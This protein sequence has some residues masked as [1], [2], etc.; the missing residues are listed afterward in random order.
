M[1][2]F[3]DNIIFIFVKNMLKIL[4]KNMSNNKNPGSGKG[5]FEVKSGKEVILCGT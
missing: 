4:K 2:W 5:K 3:I 1:I